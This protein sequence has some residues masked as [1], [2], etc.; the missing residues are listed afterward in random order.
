MEGKH[1]RRG[2]TRTIQLIQH[3]PFSYVSKCSE[4]GGDSGAVKRKRNM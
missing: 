1:T 2:K 4:V 3:V